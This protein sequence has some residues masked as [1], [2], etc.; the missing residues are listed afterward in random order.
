MKNLYMVL[1]VL[2]ALIQN[3]AWS[4]SN[5]RAET[6]LH[7]Y[8]LIEAPLQERVDEMI[9]LK[10]DEEPETR[11]MHKDTAA[12]FYK[13]KGVFYIHFS[14][15]EISGYNRYILSKNINGKILCYDDLKGK[16]MYLKD[17]FFFYYINLER[18]YRTMRFENEISFFK[19]EYMNKDTT[20]MHEYFNYLD[21][22]S[23]YTKESY[24]TDTFMR[25]LCKRIDL[26]SNE[27]FSI[28]NM[29]NFY[30]M[31]CLDK[32]NETRKKIISEII[33]QTLSPEKFYLYEFNESLRHKKIFMLLNTDHDIPSKIDLY[34]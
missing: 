25:L 11:L 7:M 32:S 17:M 20:E 23:I 8:T 16:K 22:Q 19:Q 4:K 3:K 9:Y 14:Y 26:D 5:D 13:E 18:F 30:C 34:R 31:Y 12:P 1:L 28:K 2:L 15:Y 33:Q 29:Y 24:P 27:Y 10:L 21:S 6:T